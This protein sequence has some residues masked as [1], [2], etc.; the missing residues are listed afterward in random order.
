MELN[1]QM[2]LLFSATETFKILS[3]EWTGLCS[4][5]AV[6]GT[7]GRDP[8]VGETG[9]TFVSNGTIITCQLLFRIFVTI[10][11]LVWQTI[12]CFL[13]WIMQHKNI[14]THGI[15]LRFMDI[16]WMGTPW[17]V[18]TQWSA[19][20]SIS[21]GTRY[22]FRPKMDRKKICIWILQY[23][24]EINRFHYKLVLD[25]GDR[26]LH[27]YFFNIIVHINYLTF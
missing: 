21:F 15:S 9:S 17:N 24:K 18:T 22:M 14:L 7:T 27:Q 19:T 12:S 10:S 3:S 8:S 25:I 6:R 11:K 13:K 1:R 23:K 4:V 5:G 2:V 16:S 26:F 20:K